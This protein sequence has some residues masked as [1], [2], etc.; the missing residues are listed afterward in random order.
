VAWQ[1]LAAAK[2]SY[3]GDSFCASDPQ[4]V[5]SYW[6]RYPFKPDEKGSPPCE[7]RN[8]HRVSDKQIQRAVAMRSREPR[9]TTRRTAWRPGLSVEKRKSATFHSTARSH[10]HRKFSSSERSMRVPHAPIP[11]ETLIVYRIAA[12]KRLLT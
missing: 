12:Q 10:D 11:P 4:Y 5:R 2:Q 1:V 7:R 8:N 3:C 6:A 9:T